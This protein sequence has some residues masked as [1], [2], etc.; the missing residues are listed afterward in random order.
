MIV[1]TVEDEDARSMVSK[2]AERFNFKL[3]IE[4]QLVQIP[5]RY[6]TDQ[7]SMV[8]LSL[9]SQAIGSAVSVM[10]AICECPPDIFIDT[11]GAGFGYPVVKLLCPFTKV[12]SYTHYPF[13]QDDMLKAQ[14][15]RIKHY[16]YRGMIFLYKM[17]GF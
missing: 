6:F 10:D 3:D 14:T 7:H 16:Y 2:A 13:I 11:I 12:V 17:V 4:F 8:K 9:L 15:V 1:Y 5:K